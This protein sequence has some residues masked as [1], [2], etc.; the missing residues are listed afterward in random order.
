MSRKFTALLAA[1][2]TLGSLALT[3]EAQQHRA[4]RLG[5]PATRFAKPLK[6]PDDL[7]VM[8]RAEKMKADV[9]AVL[10]DVGWAGDV[11]DLD[12]AAAAADVTA[13][14]VPTGTRLPFMAARK[15]GKAYAMRDVLWAG[16]KP[17]DAFGFEFTSK[18]V[19][20]RLVTPKACSNFWVEEI[21]KDTTSEACAPKPVVLPPV[22]SVS[23]ATNVCVTQPVD[24][25]ISVKNPPADNAVALLVN[26]KELV[27]D[28]LSNGTFHFTFTGA[29]TPGTYEIKA[30]SGGVAGVTS[31][32]VKA[33]VPTCGITAKPLPPQAGKPFTVDL[34][35]SRVAAG[36]KGGLKSAKVEV[37]DSKGKLIETVDFGAGNLTRNDVVIKQGGVHTLRAVVVDEVDETS[38]NACTAQVDVKGGFPFFVGG[39]AGKE[40]LTHD[41][42]GEVA[43]VLGSAA[44]AAGATEFSRCSPL[45]GLAVGIQPMIGT[46]AQFEAALGVKFATDSD[47]HT[48][49]YGDAAVNRVLDKGFFGGGISWWDIGK[50]SSS[51]GL[52]LQGGF[53]LD[54]DGKWQI[55]GQTRVP[56]FNQFDNIDNNYQ[57]WAGIRFRPNSWK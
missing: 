22:V 47:A 36:V 5:N 25:T 27:S 44:V 50:D 52:L 19:R 10:A 11:A 33:C 18:C 32:E 35:G 4:I 34:S 15:K 13:I 26:G 56:F 28:K 12:R 43:D 53:D 48:A 57:L 37:L 14:Q 31:V 23:G 40:R 9:A 7:R 46:K 29:R 2:L 39:Y 3:A 1:A 8:L 54:K 6:K 49:V 21:G 38:T 16:K 30:V 20:Y 24:F 45:F 55:V 51:V 17:I 42:P 41:D